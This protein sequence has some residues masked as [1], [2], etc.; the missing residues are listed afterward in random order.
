MTRRVENAVSN[1]FRNPFPFK[2]YCTV[3]LLILV[4]CFFKPLV[5]ETRILLSADEYR[6]EAMSIDSL[7]IS[8][9][10][11]RSSLTG[12][13]FKYPNKNIRIRDRSK[14]KNYSKRTYDLYVHENLKPIL[15]PNTKGEFPFRWYFVRYLIFLF[16]YISCTLLMIKIWK[17][18]S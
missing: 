7:E 8:S 9:G 13:C 16:F 5:L 17:N 3:I 14:I 2:E 6:L 11:S 4:I 12:F 18:R 1:R 10:R 15:F